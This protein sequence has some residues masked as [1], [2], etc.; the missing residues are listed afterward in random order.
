MYNKRGYLDLVSHAAKLSMKAAVEEV[1][2]LSHY[3]EGGEVI[4]IFRVH[5]HV[6]KLVWSSTVGD[7]CC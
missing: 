1:Q 2:S 7:C 5:V 4:F 3:E 6:H